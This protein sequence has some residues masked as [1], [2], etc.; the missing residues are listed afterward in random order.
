[1]EKPEQAFWLTQYLLSHL[2]WP[3][4]DDSALLPLLSMLPL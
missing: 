2:P 1:M 4:L 3:P